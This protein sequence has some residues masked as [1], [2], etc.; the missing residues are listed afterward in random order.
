MG[1]IDF[2]RFTK[3]VKSPKA[4]GKK[5][6]AQEQGAVLSL[7]TELPEGFAR[8]GSRGLTEKE[9]EELR[10]SGRGTRSSGRTDKS[11]AAIIVNNVFTLFNLLNLALGVCLF[12]VGSYRNMLFLLVAVSNT[13]ISIVQEIRARNTI[14]EMKL[15]NTPRVSVIRDGGEKSC[16]SED[17]VAGDLVVL[18]PGNQ[19]VADAIVIEGS[20]SAMES[21]LTGESNPI[22]KDQG[23]WLYSGSYITEG[24]ITAQLVYVGD[25]SYA[26][27]LME[28]TRKAKRKDSGL[29]IEERRLI[30][31][32]SA[33]LVPLGIMLFLKQYLIQKQPLE[34][35]VPSTVAAMIGM[36]PEGLMLLTS[37][38]M[39]AGVI[40]LAKRKVLT[41]E[42][43]GIESLARTDVLCLDKTG[44]ITSG[45]MK[46]EDCI[47]MQAD[48]E[49]IRREMQRF[50]G[51]FDERS[52]TMD[53]LRSWEGSTAAEETAAI[54]PFSSQRKK[55]AVSFTDG[56]TLI[57]GA[58]EFVMEGAEI[59]E[60]AR[61][62]IQRLT[63]T[64]RRVLIFTRAQGSLN[65]T[66]TPPVTEVLCLFAM[67]DEL[68]PHAAETIQYFREQGVTIK[69]IS[70][71]NPET[72][73]RIARQVN[74]AGWKKAIDARELV[75]DEDMER[76]CEEYTVFGRVTPE[77]KKQ[78]ITALQKKGHSVGMT[79]DGVNDIPA[80]KK[81]DCSIALAEGTDAA[82]HAAQLTLLESDFATVPE[83]V[84]EGRRV[85]N[86]I[87]RSASLF[88]TKT[89]F[90]LLLSLLTLVF[91]MAYPFQP[92]QLSLI[93]SMT[94][95]LPG[96]LLALEPNGDR[97]KGKF[98]KTVISRALPGG[99]AVA[100]CA[101][102]AM[103]MHIFGLTQEE[104]ATVVTWTTGM[105]GAAIL[106]RCCL[107]LTPRRI[108]IASLSTA[109]FV[110]AGVFFGHIFMLV[111][112]KSEGLLIT[113]G[114]TALGIGIIILV[115]WM[116]KK[117]Y[118]GNWSRE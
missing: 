117:N 66:E 106:W 115:D 108:A 74:L 30:R 16:L 71:D 102:L 58:P 38:A 81:A 12:L 28:E 55:S 107:P 8:T 54:L 4:A 73:S 32:D 104:C 7:P 3:M 46:V 61:D 25:E 56:R 60:K 19:V 64:G 92:I 82:R 50:L 36:I 70:G 90:S 79:G 116:M 95:G 20:G 62:E 65:G 42:L 63:G 37:I 44:T 99:V 57:L 2:S 49:E 93:S 69:I 23:D 43:Y 10:N 113:A 72:V 91:S 98:L 51:V 35:A 83:I 97:I 11:T 59:P 24:R 31:W 18:R 47:C 87:T 14:R 118:L 27:R 68:R 34:A 52:G 94:V 9:A 22:P 15:L 80:M 88:L 6:N 105:I 78:L 112:L 17:T 111:P 1:K 76:A 48:E 13:L 5:N 89:V 86:N 96:A 21:L 100:L 29:M 84:L 39:A 114:I 77:Q 53:A 33:I 67:T 41:Q 109:A 110:Q 75:T 103:Q 45:R 26:G 40:R 101:T 85:I